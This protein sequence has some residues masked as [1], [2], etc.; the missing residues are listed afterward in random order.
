MTAKAQGG[1]CEIGQPPIWPAVSGQEC[2]PV[3]GAG[4]IGCVAPERHAFM[5]LRRDLPSDLYV[6][7]WARQSCLHCLPLVAGAASAADTKITA[8]RLAL[9]QTRSSKGDVSIF[10]V[11]TFPPAVFPQTQEDHSCTDRGN[12]FVH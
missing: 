9:K 2:V 10:I 4:F 7:L 3:A 5:K 1:K 11:V 12:E 6:V 8:A